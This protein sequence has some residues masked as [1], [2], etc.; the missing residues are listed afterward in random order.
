MQVR[1]VDLPRQNNI[2]NQEIMHGIQEIVERADFILGE[3]LESF[4][5]NFAKFCGKKFCV[6]LNSGTDALKLSLIAH[7]IKEGDE[8]IT[9]PNSY[10]AT[11]SVI[12][13]I[14]ATPVFVDINPESFNIDTTKIE[15]KIS[16]KTKAILP[17]H[18]CGQTAEMTKILR[19]AKKYKLVVI[20]DACQAHGAEYMGERVPIAET[21]TFSF[22][23]GK[24]L[25]CFGDGGAVVTDNRSVYDLLILL[26][27]DGAKRKYQHLVFGYKSRL[28]NL[29]AKILDIKLPYLTKWNEARRKHAKLYTQLLS[30]ISNIKTPKEM[31][32]AKHVY[33][34]Y[35]IETPQRDALQ[36]YLEK[37]GITTVIHYPKPIHLQDP[38]KKLGYREGDFPITEEK[39]KR[40]LSLPMFP[41]LTEEEI[42]YVCKK[43]A[44]F[45]HS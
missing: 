34:L 7:G 21:G 6:G 10:F 5:K 2:Y 12:T 11:A 39:A 44:A 31:P 18:L 4:E 35:M 26:R 37:Q 33:H 3:A 14:G 41:E 13:E 38:Y 9:V 1:F 36:K 20:E 43:I 40:I 28:D 32:Y 42:R 27:N 8:V 19:P 24:N 23:P 16:K 30:N 17:V 25:G 22:Y 15:E 29:Q 45:H